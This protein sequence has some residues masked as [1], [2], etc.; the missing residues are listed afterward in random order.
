MLPASV[1]NLAGLDWDS[2]NHQLIGL[3]PLNSQVVT[4]STGGELLGN[5]GQA[6]Q[7]PA[8]FDFGPIAALR[9][10]RLALLGDSAIAVADLRTVKLFSR[11]GQLKWRTV[12]DS[13]G[14][15]S[16]FDLSLAVTNTAHVIAS[17]TGKMHFNS[18]NPGNQTALALVD[19]RPNA[20]EVAQDTILTLRN[21][22]AALDSF[23]GRPRPQPYRDSYHR[24]WG[25]AGN[26]VIFVSW[27]RFGICR[28]DLAGRLLGVV[29][30]Q[31]DRIQVDAQERER[32]L[33][34]EQGGGDHEL[35]FLHITG[36]AYYEG[37]W[38]EVG[39][40][41][42]D[43]VIAHNGLTWAIRRTAAGRA[44]DAYSVAGY[45]GSFP[46]AEGVGV[47]M[48]RSDLAV[49]LLSGEAK[50]IGVAAR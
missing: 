46:I 24:S 10:T 28:A 16:L 4:L 2:T 41:Y 21:S 11:S 13:I 5:F 36:R 44:V 40:V 3:D 37:R 30:L 34:E 7:G 9:T 22:Y 26:Q 6:G 25:I 38:P 48:L 33:N 31:A 32:V 20:R 47:A 1:A 12:V 50:V 18:R 15:G 35:P 19:L 45:D 39:P 17:E 14:G 8:D 42:Q 43:I 27:K 29:R 23:S 49:M